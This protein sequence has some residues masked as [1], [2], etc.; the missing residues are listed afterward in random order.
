M[1]NFYT[2]PLTVWKNEKFTL[3]RKIFRQINYIFCEFFSKCVTFTKLLPRKVNYM[4]FYTVTDTH[5]V[6][7]FQDLL[8]LRFYVKSILGM[9][10]NFEIVLGKF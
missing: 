2:V 6:W 1:H 3:T 4:F 5:T 9:L 10:A 8:P 7:N